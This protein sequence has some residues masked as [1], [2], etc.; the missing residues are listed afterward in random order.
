MILWETTREDFRF[1]L[2][3]KAAVAIPLDAVE[4][5]TS[6]FANT[7]Y[8]YF[9]GKRLAFPLVENY[10]RNTWAKFG[11]KRVMLDDGFF[12]FQFDTKEGMEKVIENGPWLIRLVPLILNVWTPNTILK[13]D[14]IKRRNEYARALVE[15]SS[16]KDLMESIVIAIPL[17]K[18]RGHTL[19][20]I[21]IEYEWKPPLCSNCKIFDH[22]NDHCPKLL[23]AAVLVLEDKDGFVEV[24]RK[25]NK[26]KQPRQIDGIRMTKPIPKLHYRRVEK[27][28]SSN[29]QVKGDANVI[30]EKTSATGVTKSNGPNEST[31]ASI[32]KGCIVSLKN[33]FSALEEEAEVDKVWGPKDKCQQIVSTIN[34]SDSEDV[35]EEL[36]L[37][38]MKGKNVTDINTKGASTPV[39]KV[40][41]DNQLSVCA[42]LE[43]HVCDAKL[44]KLCSYGFCNWEWTSNGARCSKGSRTGLGWNRNEV[45][46]SMISFDDQVIH[47]RLWMKADKKELFVSFIYA[48]NR[49]THRRTL[50][51]NLGVHKHY[52]R[53]TPWCI[54]GDFNAA[55]F[56]DDMAAGSSTTNISMHH[57]SAVLKL[58]ASAMVK[59]KPF[60]FTNILVHNNRFKKVVL[61]GWNTSKLRF[62][63]DKVQCDMDSDPFNSE[64]RDEDA[65]YV[66][67]FNED[68]LMEERFLRQ[69]AKID[70]LR[71]G[72]ANSA[73]F[74]KSVKSRVSRSR[75]DVVTK[76]DGVVFENERVA[77]AFVKL[78]E[79]TAHDMFRMVSDQEVKETMFSMGHDKSPGTDGFTA[80]FF[81]EAWDIVATYITQ[82]IWEFFIN[83]KLLKELNHTIIALISKVTSPTRVNDF[84]PISCCNVLFKCVSKIIANRIKESLKVLVSPNQSAFVP[85][86]SIA[87][88]ILF[89]QELMHNYHLDRGP[90]RCAFKVDIQKAY[91][92]VD[93]RF[94]KEVLIGFSFHDRMIGW[95]MECVSSTSFSI[96]INGSLHGYFKG[97]RGLRQGDPL[98]PYLFTLIMEILTLMIKRR[99]RDS[100]DFTYH[101]YCSKLELV[102]L[103]FADDLFL[104]A[105]G[106]ASSARVIMVPLDEFK[107]AAGLTPSLPK[108]GR[109]PVK[110][111]GVPLVSSRLIYKDCKELIEK[112][113]NRV[114]EW[115][116]KSLS[117]AGRIGDGALVSI[118]YDRWCPHSPLADVITSGD[119]FREGFNHSTKWRNELG[120]VKKFSVHMVWS[121]IRPRSL[122]VNWYNAVLFSSCIPRHACNLWLIIRRSLKTQDNLR[123]WDH[124]GSVNMVC[125]LCESQPDS[126]ESFA[127][128]P[129]SGH[130][131]YDILDDIIQFAKRKTLKSF[132]AKLVVAATA[133]F[134]CQERN[135]RL[136]KNV[137][138]TL[139]ENLKDQQQ[140]KNEKHE[141][142][143]ALKAFKECYLTFITVTPRVGNGHNTRFWY[144]SWVFDQ[145]LRVRSVRDG[146]ERHQWDDLNSV[147][148][149]VSLSASKD[150]WI[151]DLNGDGVFRVKEVRT[152]LDD[153]FLPSAADATRW[154]KYIPIK[155]NVFAWHARLDRLP[156]RRLKDLGKDDR[157][158]YFHLNDPFNTQ[159]MVAA[160]S[161][162]DR[163]N[164]LYFSFQKTLKISN[165]AKMKNTRPTLL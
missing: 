163:H 69:K 125:L 58:P 80:A 78:D 29:S 114:N 98:S 26:S 129:N 54:L 102:N 11:L 13:K 18:E 81:K 45:D 36:V 89:T 82:A 79:E 108:K 107:N 91:D 103:C 67:A 57:S 95:I 39:E 70:W 59:P 144:D 141:A 23:K 105:Y 126:L 100:K 143:I 38:D 44:E 73:Y 92:T 133:Y 135:S 137:R 3:I 156:T 147:S 159:K 55:L 155:I 22:T 28:E 99:V 16:E 41:F 32:P 40:I 131:I 12:L 48:H 5:L 76:N 72:D 164:Y 15:V 10:V 120:V 150:G 19:A 109:L 71:E 7:L 123:A 20:T 64:L 66:Q 62:K 47:S 160:S 6:R 152:I 27:G 157:S 30:K 65:V 140:R 149:S 115:K 25:K 75:I 9:I 136:F 87:D 88:N 111:L 104:F 94:I 101:R 2:W 83:G 43:S 127:G 130:S 97:K 162:S 1:S 96:S 68:L 46:L 60:K 93:W 146:V 49:Y 148:S 37:E 132:I 24:R 128:L 85:S 51:S 34:E 110:Y 134:I 138:R 112:V 56:F 122:K 84:R 119:I 35:D 158:A 53:H 77:D 61:E 117:I 86:R 113:Q 21:D 4:E 145:P 14:E 17:G 165:N 124:A 116:N 142:N 161:S 50:W 74:H 139:P 90:A 33:S 151:C 63:L 52:E 153:I 31:N 42:I 121:T 106:D 154:V 118:W 8:G